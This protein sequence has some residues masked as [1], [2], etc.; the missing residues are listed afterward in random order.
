MVPYLGR[1]GTKDEESLYSHFS[2][3]AEAVPDLE[4]T[5]YDAP[6]LTAIP[7]RVMKRLVDKYSNVKYVKTQVGVTKVTEIVEA[8]GNRMGV[9]CGTDTFLVPWLQLGCIGGTNSTPV[10]IPTHVRKVF[11][12]ASQKE[13]NAVNENWFKCWPVIYSF[14]GQAGARTYK[15]ALHWLGIFDNPRYLDPNVKPTEEALQYT[16]KAL[17]DLG[18]KLAR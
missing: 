14:Y 13:W 10:V 1:F 3:V 4:I 2:T 16:R 18:M 8:L 6:Y 9:F 12:A 17:L 7:V 11:E 5:L 15:H